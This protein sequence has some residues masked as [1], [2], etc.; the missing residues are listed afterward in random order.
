MKRKCKGST[1]KCFYSERKMLGREAMRLV[2][3]D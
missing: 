1:N 3:K 2:T